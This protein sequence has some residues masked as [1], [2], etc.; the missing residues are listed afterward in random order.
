[1]NSGVCN[2]A[3][4]FQAGEKTVGG[5]N[6]FI[7]TE[8][9]Q[10]NT[11]GTGCVFIGSHAGYSNTTPS[12]NTAVGRGA[13]QDNQTGN[14]NT[15]I[16]YMASHNA[17]AGDQTCV[18]ESSG[19]YLTTG[20]GNTCLGRQAGKGHSSGITGNLNTFV[21]AYAG[22]DAV[23]SADQSVGVG[24]YALRNLSTGDGNVCVGPESGNDIT[25]GNENTC[26]GNDSGRA[27]T[28]GDNNVCIG[29]NAARS[30]HPGGAI[31][32]ESNRI[33]MGD[34]TITNAYIKVAWDDSS[35]ARDKADITDFTHGLSWIN[36]LRPVTYRWDERSNYSDDLSV[37]PDGTHKKSRLN[38]GLLAQEELE[39]EKEHGYGNDK[40][41]MLIA[42]LS[43]DGTHYS[44]KYGRL[45]PIL[46]NAIKE[47]SA[48][49]TALE[50]A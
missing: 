33:C 29:R 43:S 8:A 26:L 18:G 38:L 10:E 36:K 30:G 35:D 37:V 9:G 13:S 22:Y 48:K 4:G 39:V 20:Y 16:G 23:T 50:S 6:V 24:Y 19:L 47:L 2:T 40:D 44:M 17:T 49:V 3:V 46:I 42:N 32:T 21:G 1:M 7:G 25:T 27:I 34:N 41:D 28:T 11:D 12:N 14:S 5:Y 15:C 45:V 31:T